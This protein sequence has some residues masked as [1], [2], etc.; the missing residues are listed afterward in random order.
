[1]ASN[2]HRLKKFADRIQSVDDETNIDNGFWIVLR[3]GWQDRYNPTCHT[4]HEDTLTECLDIVADAI[5]CD[6]RECEQDKLKAA[7]KA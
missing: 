7:T 5:S 4:I 6:C 1:M 2:A 3:G